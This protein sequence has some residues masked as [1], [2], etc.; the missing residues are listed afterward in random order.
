MSPTLILCEVLGT[1]ALLYLCVT[2]DAWYWWVL[3]GII[4]LIDLINLVLKTKKQQVRDDAVVRLLDGLSHGGAEAAAVPA[5]AP[6]QAQK[7]QR[8]PERVEVARYLPARIGSACFQRGFGD[9]KFRVERPAAAK[10]RHGDPVEL[11][12]GKSGRVSV[13][14]GE[15]RIG[16]I[17]PE[18]EDAAAAVAELSGSGWIRRAAVTYLPISGSVGKIEIAFY[19][20]ELAAMRKKKNA[21]K[22]KLNTVENGIGEDQIGLPCSVLYDAELHRYDVYAGGQRLGSLPPSAVKALHK[23][24]KEPEDMVIMLESLGRDKEHDR[25]TASVLVV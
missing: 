1:L 14:Y 15:E 16:R 20:D 6:A 4:V 12:I 22:V 18:E 11:R 8:E 9:V 25:P 10:R 24:D 19:R 7:I 2:E 17:S 23:Q 13:Y 5:A 21:V 3:L